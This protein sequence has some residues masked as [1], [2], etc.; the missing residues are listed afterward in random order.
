[1]DT[2]IYPYIYCVQQHHFRL[3]D[4]YRLKV[5]GWKKISHASGNQKKGSVAILIDEIDFKIK[6]KT[7]DN[8]RHYKMIKGSTKK[9]TYQ[10]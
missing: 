6:N 2:K 4:T 8:E 1:M 5:R 7:R 9:K 10:L 3:R